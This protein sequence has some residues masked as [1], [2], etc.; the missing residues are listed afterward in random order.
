MTQL[1][2]HIGLP[3]LRQ[4]ESTL[5]FGNNNFEHIQM[6]A[7]SLKEITY[8]SSTSISE[9]Q[10]EFLSVPCVRCGEHALMGSEVQQQ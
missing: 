4:H 3:E 8:L 6:L 1:P 10:V 7:G 2:L 9:A 5:A